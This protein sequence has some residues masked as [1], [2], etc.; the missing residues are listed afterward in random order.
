MKKLLLVVCS[1]LTM[2]YGCPIVVVRDP[3]PQPSPVITPPPT[4]VP[5]ETPTPIPL[6]SPSPGS[7]WPSPE[8]P[9][10]SPSPCKLPPASERECSTC[11][12]LVDYD[13]SRGN[14]TRDAQGRFYNDPNNNRAERYF[15]D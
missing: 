13:L 10:P 2:F 3:V 14:L 5:E 8:V 7:P 12:E 9:V 11:P 15:V 4:P 6:P 1:A